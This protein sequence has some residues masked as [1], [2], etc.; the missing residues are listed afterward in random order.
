MLAEK[1]GKE[2]MVEIDGTPEQ[3]LERALSFFSTVEMLS[4]DHKTVYN[5]E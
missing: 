1:G 4:N 3:A 2:P 5:L